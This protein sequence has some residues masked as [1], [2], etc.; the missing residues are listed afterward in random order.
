MQHNTPTRR[1]VAVNVV[2]KKHTQIKVKLHK[3]KSDII[4]SRLFE[5]Q[6]KQKF[7]PLQNVQEKH[8][9]GEACPVLLH[10]MYYI[11]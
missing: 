2:C 6:L 9:N 8:G 5:I 3:Q 1:L 7:Q 4:N 11:I 10:I